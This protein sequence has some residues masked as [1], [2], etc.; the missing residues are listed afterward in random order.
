MTLRCPSPRFCADQGRSYG[1][2]IIKLSRLDGLPIF[3]T[4]GAS[5]ARLAHL[6]SANNFTYYCAVRV[7]VMVNVKEIP[8]A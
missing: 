2:V 5:L 7:L 6:S 4:S 8:V 3:L 1:D